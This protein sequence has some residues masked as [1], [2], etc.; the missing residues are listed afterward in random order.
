MAEINLLCVHKKL[1]DKKMTPTL[2]KEITRR[3]NLNNIWQAY[4]T[5]GSTFPYPF[6]HASYFHRTLQP[7]KNVETGFSMLA[8]N[9]TLARYVKRFK[10]PEL[11]PGL[12]V[13]EPRLMLKKDIP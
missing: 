7:K 8:K 1:R 4:Y 12:I 10:L 3:V 13:G 9:E 6:T 11:K 2:I 5:S